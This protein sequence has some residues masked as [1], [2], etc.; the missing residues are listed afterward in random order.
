MAKTRE[1]QRDYPQKSERVSLPSEIARLDK[2]GHM[3]RVQH[4]LI[5]MIIK[6]CLKKPKKNRR[7]CLKVNQAKPVKMDT[8]SRVLK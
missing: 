2:I 4:G 3:D 7:T 6:T 8:L 5:K 1:N